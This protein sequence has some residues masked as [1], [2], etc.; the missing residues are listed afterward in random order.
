M[1]W[2]DKITPSVKVK[3]P[4]TTV[5]CYNIPVI[6]KGKDEELVAFVSI[7]EEDEVNIEYVT[8]ANT[9]F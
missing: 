4:K 8:W 2:V 9:E 1:L 5:I 7:F 3:S 6:Q